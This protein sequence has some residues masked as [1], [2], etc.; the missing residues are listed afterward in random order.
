MSK[1]KKIFLI[2]I[3]AVIA[4]F[5]FSSLKFF[6]MPGF[7][8]GLTESLGEK[9]SGSQTVG[10]VT[11]NRGTSKLS[12]T[13]VTDTKWSQNTISPVLGQAYQI[14]RLKDDDKPVAVEFSYNPTELGTGVPESSLRLFKWHDESGPGG[15]WSLVPSTVDTS[16]HVV[17]ASLTS[18]SILAVRAPLAYYLN[19]GE[20]AQ[21]DA[22]LKSLI[23]E[24]PDNT[25]GLSI[26]VEEE[27][28]EMK[29]GEI[30]EAYLRPFDE[31]IDVRDCIRNPNSP[32]PTAKFSLIIDKEHSWNNVQFQ[33][34]SYNI[35]AY[36]TW[37]TDHEKSAVIK[38]T[39]VNQKNKP[40]EGAII[41]ANK[42]KYD[43]AREET[44][45][46][47]DGK[48][49][50][51]LH[52][53]EYALEVTPSSK[54][55]NCVG[56]SWREKFFEF[57]SMPENLTKAGQAAFRHGPWNKTFTLQ[58]SEYYLNETL[59]LPID[60]NVYGVS[61][62]GMESAVVVGQLIQPISG[63][64][65]WEGT[66]EIEYSV[67]ANTKTSGVMAIMG[68]TIAMPSGA[69]QSQDHYKYKVQ[70]PLGA[71]AGDSFAIVGARTGEG[72]KDSV[73]TSAGTLTVSAN[74]GVA[75]ISIGG[76]S[77]GEQGASNVPINRTGR[78]VS[79]DGENGLIIE[80]FSM[81]SNDQPKVSIKHQ[82]E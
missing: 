20:V 48:F 38:G 50:L 22:E 11:A 65:G 75:P 80:L 18:F 41:V 16:R 7:W 68:G 51:P 63:G 76:S 47:K 6:L 14:D 70:I 66:W 13:A 58:C 9:M 15:F 31:Q 43:G 2:I 61:V 1:P 67:S 44:T 40:L 39:V 45:T 29:D 53:G 64:Y 82:A 62:K 33:N 17:S 46:D 24:T 69:V 54:D 10:Q 21:I 71:K 32:V 77:S 81:M 59:Q 5:L 74:G 57:G 78:I 23:K 55:K 56:T 72:Y 73:Q 27:L 35:V 8:S 60:S 37:Q 36:V 49:E 52:S 3:V 42:Q 12:I 25:C 19:A 79:V 30:M 26:I 4:L 34:L 28:I